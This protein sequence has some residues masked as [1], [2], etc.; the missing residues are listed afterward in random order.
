MSIKYLEELEDNVIEAVKILE[1]ER[2]W[3]YSHGLME[4]V[5]QAK[6]YQRIAETVLA[7]HVGRNSEVNREEFERA[8]TDRD[9]Y[10]Y[11]DEEKM[12]RSRK[13]STPNTLGP[14]SETAKSSE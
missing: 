1:G 3:D 5:R 6:H 13:T 4:L 9:W 12:C 11:P 2:Y 10:R 8:N 14:S 7:G